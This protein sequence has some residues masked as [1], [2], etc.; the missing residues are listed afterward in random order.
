MH[1]LESW[2]KPWLGDHLGDWLV[3]S[4]EALLEDLLEDLPEKSQTHDLSALSFFLSP[5]LMLLPF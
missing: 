3:G 4:V 2:Q 5:F 1:A